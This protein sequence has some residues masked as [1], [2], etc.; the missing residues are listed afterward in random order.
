MS[1]PKE[2][3]DELQRRRAIAWHA[4]AQAHVIAERAQ[5]GARLA[6]EAVAAQRF[7]ARSPEEEDAAERAIDQAEADLAAA[8][9][10]VSVCGA[11]AR[12]LRIGP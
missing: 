2:A 10:E 7:L 9:R 8:R 12:R 11:A 1:S 4:A 5:Q 6:L 3:Y